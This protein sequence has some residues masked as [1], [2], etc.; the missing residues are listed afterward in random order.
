MTRLIEIAPQPRHLWTKDTGDPSRLYDNDFVIITSIGLDL[1]PMGAL[2]NL[3]SPRELKRAF[4]KPVLGQTI[5]HQTSSGKTI[6]V[7]VIRDSWN[8]QPCLGS[9][10]IAAAAISSLCRD[11]KD[12]TR[13]L[14]LFRLTA[15][16]QKPDWPSVKTILQKSWETQ[17]TSVEE[18]NR[19]EVTVQ[20]IVQ[21]QHDDKLCAEAMNLTDAPGPIVLDMSTDLHLTQG[22]IRS[23]INKDHGGWGDRATGYHGPGTVLA[24]RLP[25]KRKVYYI[26]TRQ[27]WAD[28]IDMTAY[29]RGLRIIIKDCIKN[30]K[31][32][33]YTITAE[34]D[35]TVTSEMEISHVLRTTLEHTPIRAVITTANQITSS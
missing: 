7:M 3:I 23:L 10:S 29:R 12:P 16:S 26:I 24:F 11:L 33:F 25:D 20:T 14:G 31:T 2:A 6:F 28:N 9:V 22:D 17:G 35:S 21:V 19:D 30:K 27:G 34:H 32:R 5:R 13:H 18:F 15:G 1:I 8:T 4:N